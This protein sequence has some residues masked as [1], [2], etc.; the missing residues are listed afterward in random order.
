MSQ[1]GP[2]EEPLDAVPVLEEEPSTVKIDPDAPIPMDT[3]FE[4]VENVSDS[5]AVEIVDDPEIVEI[6]EDAEIVEEVE[7]AQVVEIIEDAEVAKEVSSPK[8]RQRA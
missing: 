6:I 1:G 3:D 5:Q 8:K 2:G 4:V 7:D